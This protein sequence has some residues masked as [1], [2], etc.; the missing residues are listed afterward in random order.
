MSEK[1]PLLLFS[2]GLDSTF[3]LL[4][5]LKEGPVHTCYI[6][7]SQYHVKAEVEQIK[8][9]E[10]ISYLEKA[11]GN[12]VLTDTVVELGVPK[13]VI[14]ER[15]GNLTPGFKH[16]SGVWQDHSWGQAA[17]WMHGLLFASNGNKH[18]EIQVGNVLGDSISM[19]LKD[20]QE[21]WKFTQMFSKVNHIE[22]KFPIALTSK[23]HILH[24]LPSD[25]LPPGLDLRAR[26][27]KRRGPVCSMW[28]MRC[29]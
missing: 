26:Q 15:R 13:Y 18:S 17:Q 6:V 14:K 22:L 2:G 4:L 8:R 19:C 5:A 9:Q 3:M 20:M 16:H 24:Q 10:I 23:Q 29:M 12:R 27:Q 21:A 7:G 28:R 25:L 11:T 1:H